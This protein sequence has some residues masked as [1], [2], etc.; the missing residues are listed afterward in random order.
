[1]YRFLAKQ[2]AEETN[3]G[4]LCAKIPCLEYTERIIESQD[5]ITY[6]LVGCFVL[7]AVAK[8]SYPRR[9]GE[10]ILLPLNDKYFNIRGREDALY[11]PF[12]I[13]LFAIQVVCVSVFIYL[14]FLAFKPIEIQGNDWLFVQIFA[15]YIIFVCIKLSIEKIVANIFSMDSLIDQYLH[16]KL[17]HRNFLGLVLFA[18]ILFFLYVFGP[19]RVAMLFFA[20][21]I[22]IINAIALIFSYKK[23]RKVIASNFLHFI[24]YLCALEISP[25]IILYKLFF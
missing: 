17:G 21:G 3:S 2:Y 19:S 8:Y 7:L 18:G 15:G 20:I 23:H 9:F 16:Q 13:I 1:M 12:N 14:L 4:Y 11:H 22:V 24:L 10:F 25:Y 5:W 6:L